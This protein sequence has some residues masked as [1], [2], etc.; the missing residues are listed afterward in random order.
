MARLIIESRKY[1][2]SIRAGINFKCDPG[3]IR[4]VKEFCDERNL[5]FGM[6][7]RRKEPEEIIEKDRRSMPWKVKQLIQNHGKV[8][9]VFYETEGWGKEPL[10]VVVGKNPME[11]VEI[12]IEIAKT[13][14]SKLQ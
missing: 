11:V 12:S 1:D 7:D 10:F 2:R 4:H 6:I 8:P 3:I 5:S 13:Y 9:T 14:V